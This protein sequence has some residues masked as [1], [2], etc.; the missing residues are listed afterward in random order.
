M[1]VRDHLSRARSVVDAVGSLDV[2]WDEG[3]CRLDE[4]VTALA[5]GSLLLGLDEGTRLAARVERAGDEGQDVG[6]C[7]GLTDLAPVA[8]RDRVRGRLALAGWLDVRRAG[9]GPVCRLEPVELVWREAGRP[10]VPLDPDGYRDAVVDPLAEH[11]ADL[12]LAVAR[13]RRM[14]AFLGARAGFAGAPGRGHPVRPLRLDRHGLDL[15]LDRPGD[16]VDV[17]LPFDLDATGPGLAWAG[18]EAL[19]RP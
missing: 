13:D 6:V 18:L 15:R 17:R 9:A 1:L 14:L 12:L 5:D 3:T 7:L 4:G 19:S 10:A 2:A 11:E 16:P 8:V